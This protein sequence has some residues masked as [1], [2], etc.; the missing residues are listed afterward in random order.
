LG[1][2]L[3][4]KGGRAP[5]KDEG[6]STG[7]VTAKSSRAT[8]A[9][10]VAGGGRGLCGGESGQEDDDDN[11]DSEPEFPKARRV[12]YRASDL[13]PSSP[14]GSQP[15]PAHEHQPVGDALET[16]LERRA[17]EPPRNSGPPAPA[18]ASSRPLIRIVVKG[19]RDGAKAG[20]AHPA[21]DANK[22]SKTADDKVKTTAG[23]ERASSMAAPKPGDDGSVAGGEA[24]NEEEA[25]KQPSLA[26]RE[27]PSKKPRLNKRVATSVGQPSGTSGHPAHNTAPLDKSDGA[28]ASSTSNQGSNLASK[29]SRARKHVA[30]AA[31]QSSAAAGN[32]T[33][34]PR[35]QEPGN[36][37]ANAL[38]EAPEL[39]EKHPADQL[40][41]A[42]VAPAFHAGP[43]FGSI[44]ARFPNV[45]LCFDAG[46]E[47]GRLWYPLNSR[48][49]WE[50]HWEAWPMNLNHPVSF[51]SLF[52]VQSVLSFTPRMVRCQPIS[53]PDRPNSW[54]RVALGR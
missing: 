15:V 9:A 5:E 7:Q 45:P 18:P 35:A 29:K 28:S 50:P 48:G 8:K 53:Q 22:L 54:A 49:D 2:P 38:N 6:S 30:T 36:I 17:A 34:E 52:F 44:E 47:T 26:T 11:P 40:G 14:A 31:G 25:D 12:L 51:F 13:M 23:P 3:A 10:M 39:P 46:A 42:S 4:G 33:E 32:L 37:T 1:S 27:K 21:P 43:P 19:Y 16:E 20:I 41:A 24:N